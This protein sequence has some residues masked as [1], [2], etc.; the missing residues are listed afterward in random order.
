MLGLADL[1]WADEPVLELA[2]RLAQ[3]AAQRAARAARDRPAR[4]RPTLVAGVRHATTRSCSTSIPSTEAATAQLVHALFEGCADDEIVDTLLERSGGN[5]F[6]VEELVAYVQDSESGR[7]RREA[8]AGPPRHAARPRRGPARRARAG[9]AITARG[10]RGRRRQ[11]ARSRPR[12][13]SRA[14][15]TRPALLERLAERDLLVLDGDE[16]HF[17]S[18]LI[19]EIAYGTLTKAERARRHADLAPM[20]EARGEI[21]VGHV[22]DHLATAAELVAELG[23]VPGCPRRHPR[24]RGRRARR[25]PRARPRRSS[26]GSCS[27]STTTAR[28]AS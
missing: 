6:F 9:R 23:P 25:A 5:P 28:S 13:R 12:S 16:F 11:R 18:E 20:L 27:G 14:A 26:R 4:L 10:L 19:R 24:T 7:H 2:D 3:P 8:P 22:A 17:K 21:A 1:H 15:T